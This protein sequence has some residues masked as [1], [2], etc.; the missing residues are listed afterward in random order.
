MWDKKVGKFSDFGLHAAGA[1]RGV[2]GL[3]PS[4]ARK[5]AQ[6]THKNEYRNWSEPGVHSL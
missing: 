1:R 5:G 2:L 3:P 4:A 6:G